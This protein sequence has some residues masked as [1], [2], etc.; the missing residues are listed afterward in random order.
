MLI[1]ELGQDTD[2][3]ST[4]SPS[5]NPALQRF[6][7]RV[8]LQRLLP[9]IIPELFSNLLAHRRIRNRGTPIQVVSILLLFLAQSKRWL[10]LLSDYH[11]NTAHVTPFLQLPRHEDMSSRLHSQSWPS[12]RRTQRTCP[13]AKQDTLRNQS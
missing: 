9:N 6:E 12:A 3:F 7:L 1:M 11:S 8:N 13:L 10:T 5:Q 4:S 2:S